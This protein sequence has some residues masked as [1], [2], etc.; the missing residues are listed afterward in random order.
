VEGGLSTDEKIALIN[1]QVVLLESE[2]DRISSE[3]TDL[4]KKVNA[5]EV[6]RQDIDSL[7]NEVKKVSLITRTLNAEIV[8]QL[9]RLE[10]RVIELGNSIGGQYPSTDKSVSESVSYVNR[11]QKALS[12]YNSNQPEKAITIFRQLISEDRNHDLADNSQYWI[13]ECYYS[14]DQYQQA[15]TEF[16]S[17]FSFPNT[18]KADDAQFKIGLCYAVLGSEKKSV[19]EFQKLIDYFPDSEYVEKAKQFL[20]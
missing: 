10:K 18:N 2:V 16:Q 6:M 7:K 17:V 8:S 5:I 11:Y 3:V 9:D 12:Y 13:G 4:S 1:E 15:I 20:E 14:M 19:E